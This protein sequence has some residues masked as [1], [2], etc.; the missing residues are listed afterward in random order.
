MA[1]YIPL[2]VE[3]NDKILV[4]NSRH[5]YFDSLL[6]HTSCPV[7]WSPQLGLHSQGLASAGGRTCEP[8]DHSIA[9]AKR[10]AYSDHLPAQ[11]CGTVLVLL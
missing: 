8:S 5:T 6:V 4:Y 1:K 7:G 10:S 2:P 3:Q 11:C 9:S